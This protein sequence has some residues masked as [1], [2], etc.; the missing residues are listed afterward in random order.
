MWIYFHTP[1]KEFFIKQLLTGTLICVFVFAACDATV[2]GTVPIDDISGSNNDDPNINPTIDPPTIDP[3][4]DPP[5]DPW[6]F[7]VVTKLWEPG[8]Y[9]DDE[10]TTVTGAYPIDNWRQLQFISETFLEDNTLL[11]HTYYLTDDITFPSRDTD[12]P[13]EHNNDTYVTAG[14]TPIGLYSLPFTGNFDGQGF[15]V[16]DISIIQNVN[17]SNDKIMGLFGRIGDDNNVPVEDRPLIRNLTLRNV[18]MTVTGL[19]GTTAIGSL[20]GE[21]SYTVVKKITVENGSIQGTAFETGGLIGKASNSDISHSGAS[22]SVTGQGSLGGLIGSA[23][24]STVQLCYATG[25]VTGTHNG[26]GGLVGSLLFGST[27]ENTYALGTVSTSD[28]GVSGLA[29]FTV[30]STITTSYSRSRVFAP[31]YVG[32]LIGYISDLSLYPP[33]NNFWD[34]SANSGT[35]PS[36]IYPSYGIGNEGNNNGATPLTS[37]TSASFTG[38]VFS[39]TEGWNTPADGEWPTLYWQEEN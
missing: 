15:A 29:G 27:I 16:T 32:G 25:D 17:Y 5:V 20:A 1:Y 26:V 23:V 30:A 14:W 11:T 34:P 21:I 4:V 24:G 37:P 39:T 36:G 9:I 7:P 13:D 10:G 33:R 28:S 2:S 3:P 18:N 31:E 38:F 6:S 8:E 35:P 12:V 22:A 19:T